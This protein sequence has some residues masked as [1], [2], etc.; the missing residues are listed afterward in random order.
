MRTRRVRHSAAAPRRV[1]PFA[2]QQLPVC[3]QCL[4]LYSSL[5]TSQCPE[6]HGWLGLMD[7]RA[8]NTR[9]LQVNALSVVAD[10]YKVEV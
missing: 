4:W 10:W 6:S 5:H 1:A 3:P 7:W 9:S 2:A 8:T